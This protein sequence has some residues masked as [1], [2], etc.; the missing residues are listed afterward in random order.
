M[1]P[2][3]SRPMLCKE[4]FGIRDAW[5]CALKHVGVELGNLT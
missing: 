5:A 2:M 4:L 1:F 3:L